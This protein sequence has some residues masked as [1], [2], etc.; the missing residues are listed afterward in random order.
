MSP[1]ALFSMAV[2]VAVAASACT[3]DT[4]V[5]TINGDSGVGVP[6]VQ[7]RT[8][9]AGA[10]L[11]DE[12]TCTARVRR[13][14]W[15]PRPANTTANHRLATAAEL[16]A[17]D[18]WDSAHAYDNRALALQ[19]RLTGAFTGTTDE[20]LQWVACKWGFDEDL[21]R[22]EAVESSNWTQGFHSDWTSTVADCPPDPATQQAAN[23]TECAMTYG[24]LQ[25]SWRFYKS[26]WPLIRDSTAFH[27]DYAFGLR[28]VCFEG[29][30][31]SQ[32]NRADNGIPYGANDEWGCLGAYFS[33]RWY[34]AGANTYIA[35]VQGQLAGR[36]WTRA[37][38]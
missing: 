30:D 10:T 36:A 22:A 6:A 15:E 7:F 38:F 35:R 34:D 13:S 23:G 21:V 26:A 37:D 31:A 28:R 16:A 32:A 12:A 25:I 19:A 29:L 2:L 18:R 17:I 11:P 33:G 24:I 5:A 3:I 1:R 27:L 14:A 9:R 8:L 4:R 20:I